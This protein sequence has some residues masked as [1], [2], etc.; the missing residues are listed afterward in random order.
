MSGDNG[1]TTELQP[2]THLEKAMMSYGRV[3]SRLWFVIAPAILTMLL[4]F[5]IGWTQV[6]KSELPFERMWSPR[7]G[8]LAGE[9][10]YYG[11]YVVK[12]ARTARN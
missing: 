2:N 7:G 5:N 1:K 9:W 3:V 6:S 12:P 10:D 4:V 8:R 11:D